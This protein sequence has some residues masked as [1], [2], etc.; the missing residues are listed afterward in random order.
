[1]S[2]ESTEEGLKRVIGIPGLTLS[3]INGVVGAGIFAL[4]GIVGVSLGAFSIFAYI[5]CGI[6]L[7]A[8][9]LCYAE[10]GSRIT[11]SGGSYAYVEKALGDFPGYVVN[12]L[13]FF[14]WGIIGSAALLNVLADSL[15][16][17]FPSF[18]NPFIRSILFFTLIS[19]LILIN[20]FGARHTVGIV[21][22]ITIIKLL[23]L[24]A[25]ILFGLSYIKPANLHWE[26]LPA[27]GVFSNS[28]LVLFFAFAGFETSLGASGEIKNPN[29]TVPGSLLIGGLAILVIYLLLQTVTTGIL[30]SQ[31]AAFKDAPLAAVADQIIGPV[32]ATILLI[33]AAISVFGT[34][35][36]D[37]LC[38]PRALFA[39]A[40]NG[41]FPK[42]LSK[43]HPRYA[44]PYL[45]VTTYGVLIFVF[46]I[47]GGF[48]QLAIMASACV[49]LIYLAVIL[50]T[51]KLRTK[52]NGGEKSIFKLPMG[53]TIPL[54][55]IA[56]IIW[57]LTS[58]GKWEILSTLIFIFVVSIIYFLTRWTKPNIKSSAFPG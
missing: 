46:S 12:W 1:M 19:F 50:A 33:C 28:V 21:K 58:L 42:F 47:S 34:V 35:T 36:L 2:T 24:V 14:G 25:I 3:I 38:T 20:V 39:G 49:L 6:M 10:I 5:F 26:H 40:N 44:T 27:T 29:R 51:I 37:M 8:I 23:P 52:I 55:G 13:Y 54:I 15:A 22:I 31:I 30:G 9:M 57:V 53:L 18:Y 32:G 16:G 48:K 43:V 45:A 56:S 11:G 4:P 17:I 7:A 41:L